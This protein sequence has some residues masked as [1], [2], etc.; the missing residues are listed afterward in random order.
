MKKIISIV[1]FSLVLTGCFATTNEATDIDVRPENLVLN[2]NEGFNEYTVRDTSLEFCMDPAW[3]EVVIEDVPGLV[4][5]LVH[6]SFTNFEG[7]IELWYE[8]SDYEPAEGGK[9][10]A[11]IETKGFV[12]PELQ[13]KEQ[14][15]EYLDLGENDLVVKKVDVAAIRAARVTAGGK[16]SYYVPLAFDNYNLLISAD[17]AFATEVDEFAF[18]TIF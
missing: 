7:G 11:D 16:L 8:S 9:N 18:D 12:M 15:M 6:V 13:I 3:G 14:M 4:G 10:Y 5:S 2:C 17:E 1:I